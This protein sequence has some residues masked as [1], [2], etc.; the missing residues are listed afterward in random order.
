VPHHKISWLRPCDALKSFHSRVEVLGIR[1]G[2]R[3]AGAL[4]N[5]V[6]EMGAVVLGISQALRIERNGE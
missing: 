4:I 6:Y 2:I 5:R 3:E 1:I